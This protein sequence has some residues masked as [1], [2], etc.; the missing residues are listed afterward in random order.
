VSNPAS[1]AWASGPVP[2]ARGCVFRAKKGHNRARAGAFFLVNLV[3]LVHQREQILERSQAFRRPQHQIAA[4]LQG[5]EKRGNGALLQNRAEINQQIPAADQIQVGKGRVLNDILSGEYAQFPDGF[6]DLV[7]AAMANEETIEPL[8][9]NS[10]EF[11]GGV[12]A[13]ARP[14]QSERR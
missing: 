10:Q 3:L 8:L 7:S 4:W 9:G 2:D 5:I 6:V 12:G 13:A 11:A 1:I 14:V